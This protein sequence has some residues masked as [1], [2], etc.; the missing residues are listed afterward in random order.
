[1]AAAG[2]DKLPASALVGDVAAAAPGSTVD[3][4]G[5]VGVWAK[6][7]AACAQIAAPNATDFTVITAATFRNSAGSCTGAFGALADGKASLAMSCAGAASTVTVAQS[8]P[9]TLTIN[10][11]PELVRCKP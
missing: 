4:F 5:Y 1:M 11:G 3:G 6:D 7:A 8:A 9:D 10:D 2:D